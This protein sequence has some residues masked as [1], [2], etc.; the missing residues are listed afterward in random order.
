MIISAF[1]GSR[2]FQHFLGSS[3]G[4][5][6]L[7]KMSLWALVPSQVRVCHQPPPDRWWR[8]HHQGLLPPQTA[9]NLEV[10]P[11]LDGKHRT[12]QNLFLLI[13]FLAE[14][15]ELWHCTVAWILWNFPVLGLSQGDRKTIQSLHKQTAPSV[16]VGYWISSLKTG[17]WKALGLCAGGRYP[18]KSTV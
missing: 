16:A 15:F 11:K 4:F 2:C 18:R 14:W 7:V 13:H 10:V 5:G 8:F 6:W 17:F 3:Q 1:E 12:E 9:Y